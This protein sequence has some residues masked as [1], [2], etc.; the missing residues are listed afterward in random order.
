MVA[1]Y[2][3][4]K[5]EPAW[6]YLE[7][8][9]ESAFFGKVSTPGKIFLII[10]AIWIF[11]VLFVAV[12]ELGHASLAACFGAHIYNL[13]INP[14]G[15]DGDTSYTLI[16]NPAESNVVVAGGLVATTLAAVAL[17]KLKMELGVYVIGFRSLESLL[18]FTHNSDMASL[19][20]GAGS[21]AYAISLA[22]AGVVIVCMVATAYE[23][24]IKPGNF[25]LF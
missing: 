9:S 20:S 17:S 15:L 7:D 23:N 19:I 12:H 13:Y 21:E 11:N 16:S 14:A 3:P 25:K 24:R 8:M 22:L 10:F 4:R 2:K 1:A 18:N 5:A 6:K